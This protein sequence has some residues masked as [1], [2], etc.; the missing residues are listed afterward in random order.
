MAEHDDT[1]KRLRDQHNEHAESLYN[2]LVEAETEAAETKTSLASSNA[3]IIKLKAEIEELHNDVNDPQRGYAVQISSAEEEAKISTDTIRKLRRD[4]ATVESKTTSLENDRSQLSNTVRQLQS[5]IKSRI[6]EVERLQAQDEE[7]VATIEAPADNPQLVE[8]EEELAKWHEYDDRMMEQLDHILQGMVSSG[9]AFDKVEALGRTLQEAR[10][11]ADKHEV[12]H[13]A[14]QQELEK[15]KSQQSIW[16]ISHPPAI[17]YEPDLIPAYS[18][19]GTQTGTP[20]LTVSTVTIVDEQPAIPPVVSHQ[21]ASAQTAD[22]A[23]YSSTETQTEASL[24]GDATTQTTAPRSV[25]ATVQTVT[26][27]LSV[28]S[29]QTI[30]AVVPPINKQRD[31]TRQQSNSIQMRPLTSQLQATQTEY[32]SMTASKKTPS[33]IARAVSGLEKW[34]LLSIL[35]VLLLWLWDAYT[36]VVDN[37]DYWTL[38]G[39]QSDMYK[40]DLAKVGFERWLGIDTSFPG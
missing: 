38:S 24:R 8:A 5:Q 23:Q 3:E 34:V 21:D 13:E 32:L 28:A 35:G 25:D 31:H 39:Y 11:A 14:A 4:L 6:A 37:P 29:T 40:R 22:N 12:A 36:R 1:I 10:D 18:T 20:T 16:S 9:D 19:Q 26:P 7:L 15:R 27:S 2:Q 30:S 33:Q 17:S